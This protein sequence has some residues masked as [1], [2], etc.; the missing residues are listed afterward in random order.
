M[1]IGLLIDLSMG[2]KEFNGWVEGTLGKERFVINVYYKTGW[3]EES[4][5]K[6]REKVKGNWDWMKAKGLFI[7]YWLYVC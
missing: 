5:N 1:D 4:F 2:G 6:Y 3:F 7:I